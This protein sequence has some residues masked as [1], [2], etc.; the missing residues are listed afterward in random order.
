[1]SH[2]GSFGQVRIFDDFVGGDNSGTWH[3]SADTGGT[4]AVVADGTANLG[5]RWRLASDT[6]DNDMQE[7]ASGLIFELAQGPLVLETRIMVETGAVATDLAINVGFT[8][9]PTEGSNSLPMEIATTTLTSNATSGVYFVYDADSTADC[10]QVVWVDDDTDTV[11]AI[12]T[13][14]SQTA[15]A[16]ITGSTPV[17]DTWQVLRMELT[18][19]SATSARGEFFIDGVLKKKFD[20]IVIDNNVP[21]ACYV[22]MENRSTV[23]CN[24]DIDYIYASGGRGDTA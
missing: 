7:V 10:W 18:A 23:A 16:M 3:S 9:D 8:D 14:T 20:N 22:G 11:E 4:S 17:A 19:T 6:T 2:I 21:L 5:G 15:G 24:V 1:M 13:D 12:G